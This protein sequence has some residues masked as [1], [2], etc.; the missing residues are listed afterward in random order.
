MKSLYPQIDWSS[1]KAVGLDLDG[2]IYDEFEFIKQVYKPIAEKISIKT[3]YDFKLTFSA[4]KKKWLE[5]GSSYNK[6]FLEELKKASLDDENIEQII[7]ECLKTFRTFKPKI[8]LSTRVA[9]IL[10]ELKKNYP[11][12]LVTDGNYDLQMSKISS[13]ELNRWISKQDISI[14]GSYKSYIQK[15][16]IRMLENINLFKKEFLLPKNVVFFGDR[17]VD[18]MFAFN[19]GFHF[20]S[21]R[22]MENNTL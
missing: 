19:C 11:L 14:S 7:Y 13:L 17:K 2:T 22:C 21:V 8:K 18:E 12:F 15:P 4:M 16:N 10:N 3:G 9:T 5:K 1:I 20:I 6:I